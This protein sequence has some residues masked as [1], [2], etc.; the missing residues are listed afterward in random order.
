MAA[1]PQTE[2]DDEISIDYEED[3]AERRDATLDH[4]EWHPWG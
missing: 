2:T 4:G 3:L 1:A